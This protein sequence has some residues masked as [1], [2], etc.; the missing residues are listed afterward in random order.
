MNPNV[1]D[2]K[3]GSISWVQIPDD[4][5]TYYNEQTVPHGD[6]HIH[7]YDSEAIGDTRRMYIYTPPGYDDGA[8]KHYPVLY[9]LHGAGQ[10]ESLWTFLGRANVILD[11]LIAAGKAEPMI[12]VMPYGHLSRPYDPT[13]R[14]RRGEAFELFGQ[15]LLDQIVPYIESRY[16]VRVDRDHRALAGLSMGAAQTLQI[17]LSHLELFGW[18]GAFSG[19]THTIDVDKLVANTKASGHPLHLLW[20]GCSESERLFDMNQDLDKRLSEADLP[21]IWFTGPGGHSWVFWRPSL[22]DFAQ[23][24]FKA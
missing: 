12:I 4:E 19:P 14:E 1:Q 7:W 16:R 22:H 21:H 11:N 17:G 10:N 6:V 9:L 20:V 13:E 18:I 2:L 8:D 23:R 15:D 24:I 3:W 5:P